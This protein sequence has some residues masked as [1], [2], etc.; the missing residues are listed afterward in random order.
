MSPSAVAGETPPVIVEDLRKTFGT[1]VAVDGVSFQ[2]EPGEVVGLLGPNGAGKTTVLS[3]L[4][5]LVSPTSGTIRMLGKDFQ[6]H[7]TEILQH[8][9]FSSAYVA[10]PG[11]LKVREN[12]AVFGHLYGVRNASR[13]IDELLELFEVAH[14]RNSIT[15]RLSSGESARVNLCKALLNDP[16]LLLLDEPTASLDP[17]MADKFRKVLCSLQSERHISMI[18]TSHNMRDVEEVCDRILF[19]QKGRIIASGT[20]EEI[21]EHFKED[22]LEDVFIQVARDGSVEDAAS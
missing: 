17:D 6:K 7:R 5:G 12:L 22:T 1:M 10:L 13:K 19:L 4:L 16:K 20:S 21:M 3:M 9:N 8:C 15:G 18:Y 14:L 11:N 2:V